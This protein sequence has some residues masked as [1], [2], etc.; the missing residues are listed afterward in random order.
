MAQE[1]WL[2]PPE[3]QGGP[4][5]APIASVPVVPD[6]ATATLPPA[7]AYQ[8]RPL[9]LGEVLDRTFSMYRSRFWL[10]AGIACLSSGTYAVFNGLQLLAMHSARQSR[11]QTTILVVT[12]AAI[13]VISIV[14][15]LAYSVT[16]AATAFALSEVYLGNT[17]SIGES[18]RATIGKWYRY[19]GIGIWQVFSFA[20]LPLLLYVPALVLI[21]TR[22]PVLLIVGIVLAVLCI[23]AAVGGYI[24]YLRNA[25]A[26]PVSVVEATAIRASMKRSKTLSQ[27]AKGRVFVV[28]LIIV[29]LYMGMALLEAP[30]SFLLLSTMTHGKEGIGIQI[31]VMVVNFVCLTLIEPVLTIALSLLYFDQRVRQEALDLQ[32]LMG[33]SPV[34]V[35][36]DA[37]SPVPFTEAPVDQPLQSP[38]QPQETAPLSEG[39]AV[40]DLTTHPAQGNDA[41]SL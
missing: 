10:F 13:A 3:L 37:I 9:S 31:A 12:F 28:H 21:A 20:W 25:L 34:P 23:P 14:H 16:Q 27:G 22:N 17:T 36:A 26:V 35:S 4:Y 39:A 19:I 2:T 32:I 11:N 6:P 30:L 33:I 38:A 24:L 8:L 7:P 40:D 41:P 29:A 18:F 5:G 15:F 1:E